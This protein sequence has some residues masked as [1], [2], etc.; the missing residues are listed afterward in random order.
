[1]K[2]AISIR[3]NDKTNAFLVDGGEYKAFVDLLL[4]I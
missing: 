2:A 1:M 3:L 4:F